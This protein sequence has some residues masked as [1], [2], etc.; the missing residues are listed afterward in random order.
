MNQLN[1]LMLGPSLEQNG[2][3]ATLENLIIKHS[4]PYIKIQHINSHDEGSIAYR[5][6]VFGKSLAILVW[7]LLSQK[8]DV[9]HI[10]ISGGGSILRKAIFCVVA[11]LFNK[12]VL[13]HTNGSGFHLTYAKLPQLAQQLVSK[14]FQRCQG[15]IVVSESWQDYYILNLGLNPK[16][17]IVLPNP[18]ELPTQIPDRKNRSQISLV[19]CGRVG[20]R[21]GAF[22]LIQAFANLSDHQRKCSRLIM[23]G[24]GEIEKAQQLAASLNLA[25]EIT[26][27]G[28]INSEKRDE[29]LSQADVFILPSY[30][31]GLPLAIVEAMSWSL[32]VI[33]TPVGGI[34]ELVISNKN[35]LLVPPGNIQQL[36]EAMELLIENETLRLSLGSVARQNV[37]PLDIKNCSIRLA[38]IYDSLSKF[39]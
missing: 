36:S 37:E 15:F 38:D 18:S 4:L 9:V 34:P 14:I 13:M 11:F 2:G 5:L 10:H 28:W 8:I 32:P 7:K 16:Q 26:F 31:E 23:A 29:V 22:D 33:S 17:V 24:D 35:G 12:P 1:V 6:S 21:K 25:D 30:N 39:N 3:I 27:L 20:E 19:F